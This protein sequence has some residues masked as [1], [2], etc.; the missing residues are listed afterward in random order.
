[1]PK[2]TVKVEE[3]SINDLN[4]LI[5]SIKKRTGLSEEAISAGIKY[6][7]GYIAQ[8]RSRGKVPSKFMQAL[9]AAYPETLQNA[10]EV[11]E[12]IPTYESRTVLE[13]SIE[14]LTQDKI[15]TTALIERI[16]A[17]LEN[18]INLAGSSKAVEVLT[19]IDTTKVVPPK[20]IDLAL[21]KKYFGQNKRGTSLNKDK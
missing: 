6:N 2:N 9:K 13:K 4:R 14:N 21:D 17:Y 11:N 20:P 1:M 3:Y 18:Q 15:R 5:E 16:M 19:G 8:T 7:E 10:N 12:P